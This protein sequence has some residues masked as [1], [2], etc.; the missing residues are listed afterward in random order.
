MAGVNRMQA[1][2]ALGS[3]E[4]P[5]GCVFVNNGEIIGRGMNDTNK[6]LNVCTFGPPLSTCRLHVFYQ[7]W[8]WMEILMALTLYPSVKLCNGNVHNL[9]N[10]LLGHPSC[11][12]CRSLRHTR[13]VFPRRLHSSLHRPIRDGRAMHYVCVPPPSIWNQSRLLWMH[14]RQIRRD[15]R[16]VLCP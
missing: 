13:Q 14:K 15:W 10:V 3:D 4:T 1:E 8:W 16:R 7:A 11:R 9:I 2:L 5:V 12:V 6:S